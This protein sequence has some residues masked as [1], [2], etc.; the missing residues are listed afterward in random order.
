[1][2]IFDSPGRE[3]RNRRVA[4][5]VGSTPR[6]GFRSRRRRERRGASA[7]F[8]READGHELTEGTAL[9]RRRDGDLQIG[10]RAWS[11]RVE[12]GD[13]G[14][15]A[16]GLDAG[17]PYRRPGRVHEPEGSGGD[18]PF[19]DSTEVDSRGLRF[20]WRGSPRR[21]PALGTQRKHGSREER[22]D[23]H[24]L[25]GGPFLHGTLTIGAISSRGKGGGDIAVNA[26]IF[27]LDQAISPS[28]VGSG[29]A[30]GGRSRPRAPSPGCR[31]ARPRVR[32]GARRRRP[33]RGCPA[34]RR[35][36]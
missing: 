29:R 36:W 24:P 18:T 31:W 33:R 26:A 15:S 21:L 17:D 9:A 6:P 27:G 30:K 22:Q 7:R 23:E 25:R 10:G 13:R 3:P 16:R 35:R 8:V 11:K 28:R 34:L 19:G 2:F 5:R 14:A 4:P 20:K 1:M 32:R 12:L